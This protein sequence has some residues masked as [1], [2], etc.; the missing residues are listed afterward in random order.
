MVI[1]VDLNELSAGVKEALVAEILEKQHTLKV[2]L[3]GL[4]KEMKEK[5]V[6]GLLSKGRIFQGEAAIL[7]G[8]CRQDLMFEVMPRYQIPLDGG[9]TLEE[10][11]EDLKQRWED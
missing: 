7:L 3:D 1:D 4:P 2:E 10:F 11:E 9:L 6:M 5:V 8:I